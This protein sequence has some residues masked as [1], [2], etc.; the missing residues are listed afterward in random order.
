MN[1][2]NKELI[3]ALGKYIADFTGS[4]PLDMHDWKSCPAVIYDEPDECEK[5]YP[6]YK[7]WIDYI[8]EGETAQ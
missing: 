7:C 4:C 3:D 8:K 6:I 5:K 2:N 1:K